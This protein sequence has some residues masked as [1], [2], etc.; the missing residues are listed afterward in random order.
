MYVPKD[1]FNI[2]IVEKVMKEFSWPAEYTLEEDADGVSIIFPKSEIYIGNGYENDVYFK[3]LSFNGR[4]C[5]IHGA[6]AIERI[7]ENSEKDPNV[8]KELELK[9]NTTVYASPEATEDNIWDVL[10]IIHVYFQDFI[11]GKEKRLNSLL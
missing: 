2:S 3:L 9:D 5:D 8:F 6:I 11:T 1:Y 10:K 7:V 4:D